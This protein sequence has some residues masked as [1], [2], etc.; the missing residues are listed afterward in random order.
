MYLAL[1]HIYPRIDTAGSGSIL[2]SPAIEVLQGLYNRNDKDRSYVPFSINAITLRSHDDNKIVPID[3]LGHGIYKLL[4][5]LT[6]NYNTHKVYA[7]HWNI[8]SATLIPNNGVVIPSDKKVISQLYE[9]FILSDK[10]RDI[11]D[12]IPFNKT[13]HGGFPDYITKLHNKNKEKMEQYMQKIKENPKSKAKPP[14]QALFLVAD[15]E[16]ICLEEP[17]NQ[18]MI[19]DNKKPRIRHYA[20]A[21]A[22]MTVRP[23]CELSK[24]DIVRFCTYDYRHWETDFFQQ[25]R[26][27]IDDFINHLLIERKKVRKT[28][29]LYFHNMS[30]FD[31]IIL[32]EYL[33]KYRTDLVVRP[34]MR[35]GIIYEI[36]IYKKQLNA[37]NNRGKLLIIIRCSVLLLPD[38]LEKLANN[39][40]PE[41]GGKGEIDHKKVT[42][43]SLMDEKSVSR[44]MDYLCQ[45]VI[46]LA[47][48]MQVTQNFFWSEFLTDITEKRTIASLALAIFRENYYDDEKHRMYIPNQNA[49][50][51]IRRGYYGGH[52]DVYI[53]YGEKL[54]YYD[55]N[56][57]YPSRM[58]GQKFPG[59]K[60]VWHSDLSDRKLSDLFGFVEA[61]VLSPQTDRPFLPARLPDENGLYYPTGYMFGV[62]YTEELKYAET[63]GYKVITC[64]CGYLFEPMDSP[65]EKYVTDLYSRRLKAKAAGNITASY[66]FKSLLNS[67]YGRLAISPESNI[68]AVLDYDQTKKYIDSGGPMGNIEEL[69]DVFL[70]HYI[71]NVYDQ[72]APWK[73]HVNTSPQMSAAITSYGRI[74]MYPYISRSDCHYTDTDSVVLSNPLPDECVSDTELGKFKLEHNVSVGIFTAPKCY[75]ISFVDTN[76]EGLKYIVRYKGAPRGEISPT[77]LKNQLDSMTESEILCYEDNFRVDWKDFIVKSVK[78]RMSLD[79]TSKKRVKIFNDNNMWVGTT[80]IVWTSKNLNAQLGEST[81]AGNIINRILTNNDVLRD[82]LKMNDENE[83]V[84]APDNDTVINKTTSI[85]HLPKSINIDQILSGRDPK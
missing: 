18:K 66:V 39:M 36:C 79:I 80:P 73:H 52:C 78:R 46:L 54:Y 42:L 8:Y 7:V 51:F 59:G 85:R 69:G 10:L 48:C 35:N 43:T 34:N 26:N 40:C 27:M 82:L 9:C 1:K 24:S 55:A 19:N 14:K 74:Y 71:Q 38:P 44:Y 17:L 23:D 62:Y 75:A 30:K 11:L 64:C 31:G 67:L 32:G 84:L 22:Y 2:V 16:T 61:L 41:L 47:R 68:T 45:D 63:L 33:F 15:F 28:V 83:K 53:P 21:A 25:S 37:V 57:L 20:Y 60:P 81:K 76:K 58:V 72:S 3:V 49:D 50:K 65:F 6:E 29:I 70:L 4:T 77:V 56:S 13:K 5:E 12:L